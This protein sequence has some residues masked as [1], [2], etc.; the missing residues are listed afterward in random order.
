MPRTEAEWSE[1]ERLICI[2]EGIVGTLKSI[3]YSEISTE[4]LKKLATALS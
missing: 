3:P 2:I 1:R 4:D